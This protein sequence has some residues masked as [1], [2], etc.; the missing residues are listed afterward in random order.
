VEI[1]RAVTLRSRGRRGSDASTLYTAGERIR[2]A[3]QALTRLN[4]YRGPISGQLDDATRRALFEYQV[5]Q[6][7]NPTGNLDGRTAQALGITGA[8]ATTSGTMLS[9]AEASSVRRDAQ[10]LVARHRSDL[11]TSSVGRLDATRTYTQA[12]LDLWFA[13]SAFAD[14]A[15]LYE[16]VVRN[17]TNADGAVLAGRSLIAA[18]RRVDAALQNARTSAVIQASWTAMRRRLA[19]LDTQP[20]GT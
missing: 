5:D 12:D 9:A 2:S 6:R 10:A 17:G 3:Q 1:Q 15:S 18:A 16:Q 4:Y 11:A 7:L 14:N 19:A 13:L 8:G 20:A